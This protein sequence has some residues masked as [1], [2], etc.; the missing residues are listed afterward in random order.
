MYRGDLE[1]LNKENGR[2]LRQGNKNPI[3][4]IFR[5][6]TKE[7]F[8]A[9]SWQLIETKQKFISQIYRGD[10]SVRTLEDLDNQI[11]SYAQIKAIASGNPLILEKFKIDTEVQ[12]LKDRE[13][14]YNATKYRLED[15]IKNDLPKSIMFE[16]DMIQRLEIDIEHRKEKEP[17]DNCNIQINGKTF[18]TYKDAGAEILEFANQ[19]LTVGKEYD[20]GEYRGFKFVMA[21]KGVGNLINDEKADDRTIIIKGKLEHSFELLK[22]PSLNIKKLDEMIDKFDKELEHQRHNKADF[23]RQIEQG[24]RELEKPFEQAEKLK[25]L[26]KRQAE[27]NKELDM[28]KEDKEIIVLDDEETEKNENEIS[29]SEKSELEDE[30]YG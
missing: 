22:V 15:S 12:K 7:S 1:M 2:I 18:H 8:D 30:M 17:E 6:V 19:Y 16:E 4:H 10:T 11:M 26:L 9:Y 14:N 25:E 21:N 24:K 28:E 27:I 13:R 23:E 29:E 3:V 20:L 5:Y